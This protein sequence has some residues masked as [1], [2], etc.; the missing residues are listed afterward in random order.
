MLLESGAS[1]H[2]VKE[3]MKGLA[4]HLRI[5]RQET[6][7]TL[8]SLITT[9]YKGHEFRTEVL[10]VPGVGVNATITHETRTYLTKLPPTADS[11]QV[12]KD[13]DRIQNTPPPY[14]RA[15][16]AI[17]AGAA[18]AGFD[19]LG[20]GRWVELAVVFISALLGFL[21]QSKL[22][23]RNYNK[24]G[25][26]M[27]TSG[28][29]ATLYMALSLAVEVAFQIP[30]GHHAGIIAATLFLI[31]GVPMVT[32]VAEIVSQEYS[33]GATRAI[34]AATLIAAAGS[35][36]WLLLQF[37]EWRVVGGLTYEL[38]APALI[39][40]QALAKIGRASCRERV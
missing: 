23:S 38:P 11:V 3:F 28:F 6:A 10:E 35:A 31:P 36:L 40:L 21:V 16:T 8:N 29:T 33:M 20:G 34:F 2:A 15:V 32:A 5:D 22:L 13:L 14:S 26:W 12:N 24:F 37:V 30:P 27:V 19:F 4:H 7:I 39:P 1:A 18:C 17:A 9:S 25:A